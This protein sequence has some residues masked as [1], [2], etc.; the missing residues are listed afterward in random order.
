MTFYRH[1][2]KRMP[3]PV[4]VHLT[5]RDHCFGWRWIVGLQIGAWFIGVINGSILTVLNSTPPFD[6][7]PVPTDYK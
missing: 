3:L 7:V 4:T 5:D 6:A 2:F 1:H